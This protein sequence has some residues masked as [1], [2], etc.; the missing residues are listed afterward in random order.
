MIGDSL[1]REIII[2]MLANCGVVPPPNFG[3]VGLTVDDL[4]SCRILPVIY[5]ENTAVNH[6]IYAGQSE[7]QGTKILAACVDLTHDES[8]EY[9]LVLRMDGKPIYGIR[10]TYDG[11]DNVIFVISDGGGW[12]HASMLVKIRALLGMEMMTSF[13]IS[14]AKLDDIDSLCDAIS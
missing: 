11:E 8:I 9:A 1:T 13:G 12:T 3:H 10:I 14:W 4:R 7:I 6:T 5:D 2:R